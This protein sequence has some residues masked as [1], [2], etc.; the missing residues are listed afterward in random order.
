MHGASK[1]NMIE[2]LSLAYNKITTVRNEIGTQA[3]DVDKE[4]DRYYIQYWQTSWSH[5]SQ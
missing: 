3:N 5:V 4:I 2:E 1:I